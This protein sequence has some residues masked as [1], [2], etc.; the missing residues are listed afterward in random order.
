MSKILVNKWAAYKLIG[1]RIFISVMDKLWYIGTSMYVM[2]IPSR[3]N[4]LRDPVSWY[5]LREEYSEY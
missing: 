1:T 2:Y 5:H 4:R 3:V